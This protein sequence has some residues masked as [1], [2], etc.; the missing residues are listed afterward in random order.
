[1]RQRQPLFDP[2]EPAVKKMSYSCISGQQL[3]NLTSTARA[4]SEI[5]NMQM[6]VNQPFVGTAAFAHKGGIHVSAI[7][8]NAKTYEHISPELVGNKQRVLVSEL[9][10]QSNLMFKAEELNLD[11]DLNNEQTKQVIQH[12]KE[13]EHQG[14]QF[15]GADASLELILR[16]A[17]G[18]MENIFTLESFKIIYEKNQPSSPSFPRRS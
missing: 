5:A 18:E 14:Y 17:F 13:L 16:E 7:L 12:I 10:G 4:V 8:K 3:A 2:A 15:E 1:M 11:F 9:A 6:P